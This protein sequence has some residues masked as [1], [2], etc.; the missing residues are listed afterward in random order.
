MKKYIAYQTVDSE[1]D[2]WCN[3]A[4]LFE[5]EEKVKEFF[6]NSKNVIEALEYELEEGEEIDN[7]EVH[8]AVVTGRPYM[9]TFS[10][11]YAGR[12]N[13]CEMSQGYVI[14]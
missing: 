10:C 2:I 6:S 1:N 4:L 7:Y 14:L 11:K 8:S 9:I 3:K 5:N 12:V 13:I